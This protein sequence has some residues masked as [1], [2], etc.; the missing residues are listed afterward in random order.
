MVSRSPIREHGFELV[1]DEHG[2]AP[3]VD[4]DV[5]LAGLERLHDLPAE[6]AVKAARRKFARVIDFL[7]LHEAANPGRRF[8]FPQVGSLARI[9]R[10]NPGACR[11]RNERWGVSY[12]GVLIKR[13][14]GLIIL[15]VP[16]Q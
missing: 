1:A 14:A 5:V 11:R 6:A 3:L 4:D 2:R 15:H 10:F 12:Q 16:D 13:A 9:D 7:C 8:V